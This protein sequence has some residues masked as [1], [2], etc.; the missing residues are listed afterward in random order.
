VAGVLVV[1]AN[2]AIVGVSLGILGLLFFLLK[3]HLRQS[4]HG[5]VR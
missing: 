4:D 2:L 3:D 1:P 5:R